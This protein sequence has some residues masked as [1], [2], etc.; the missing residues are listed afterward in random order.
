M[1]YIT[2]LTASDI[3]IVP[4]LCIH[5]ILIGQNVSQPEVPKNIEPMILQFRPKHGTI[6]LPLLAPGTSESTDLQKKGGGGKPPQGI[7]DFCEAAPV[8]YCLDHPVPSHA[9]LK[10]CWLQKSETSGWLCFPHRYANVFVILGLWHA[11]Y[12][13]SHDKMKLVLSALSAENNKKLLVL[14]WHQCI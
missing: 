4:L 14:I 9:Q 12:T 8:L 11:R 2:S 1:F 10:F 13:Y 6:T 3:F 7:I 5:C